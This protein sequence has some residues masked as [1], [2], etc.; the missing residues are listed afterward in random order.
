MSMETYGGMIL[1]GKNLL[2]HPPELSDN[3]TY[4]HLKTSVR[5]EPKER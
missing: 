1:T 3:P 5:N 4:S 2:I